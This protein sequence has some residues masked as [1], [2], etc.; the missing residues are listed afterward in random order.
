MDELNALNNNDQIVTM[1]VIGKYVTIFKKSRIF[2]LKVFK[3]G[4]WGNLKRLKRFIKII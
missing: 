4:K 2:L 3:N 1:F